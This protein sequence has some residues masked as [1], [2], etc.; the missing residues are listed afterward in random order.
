MR[1][2]LRANLRDDLQLVEVDGHRMHVFATGDAD[3]PRLVLMAGSGT[4][5]PV[6][7]FKV[8][9][10][11]LAS[12]FR[13]IVVEKFGYGYSDLHEGPCDIDSL[14]S[15]QRRALAQAG[16]EG[17]YV[18]MPHSMSGLEAIRW[19]QLHPGEVKA[20]IGLDMATPRSYG[21]WD[22]DAVDRR[23]RLMRRMRLLNRF[24]LLFWYPL[25]TRALSR[26]EARQQRLLFRRNAMNACYENEARTVLDNAAIVDA[27]G[28]ID[29]P[30]L[31]FV[32]DG[33]QTSPG[34]VGH[35]LEFAEATGARVVQLACGHY[36]HHYE[37]RRICEEILR[38]MGELGG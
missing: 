5:A 25:S 16:E 28:A 19:G 12:D 33:S 23:I 30:V 29:C 18:L 27:A 8:L 37:S 2:G 10:E 31:M 38:F 20:I 1:V 17:P 13:V 24:G 9:Y 21:A 26:E 3:K 4:V 15:L 6:Y 7:D 11:Q 35:A 32:S 22:K 36:V 34:W 14:V